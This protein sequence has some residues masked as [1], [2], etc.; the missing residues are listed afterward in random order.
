MCR[1]VVGVRKYAVGGDW[2]QGL[3][4]N[5]AGARLVAPVPLQ[6]GAAAAR[7]GPGCAGPRR[8]RRRRRPRAEHRVVGAVGAALQAQAGH[9]HPAQRTPGAQ[10]SR[11]A[12]GP[13]VLPPSAHGKTR[14]TLQIKFVGP[15]E[16][17]SEWLRALTKYSWQ[18]T[19]DT[20]FCTHGTPCNVAERARAPE[21]VGVVLEGDGDAG[22]RVGGAGVGAQHHAAGRQDDVLHEG[23]V[24]PAVALDAHRPR[25]VGEAD[26]RRA[27]GAQVAAAAACAQVPADTPIVCS[28]RI[29]N[30]I[31]PAPVINA[32]IQ[33][34]AL[35]AEAPVTI[36]PRG[37]FMPD[38]Y[39]RTMEVHIVLD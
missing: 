33:T 8:R 34:R 26:L 38:R 25:E 6:R 32:A 14:W 20:H 29:R 3:N 36:H 37:S 23:D 10:V 39:T 22:G 2:G 35:A 19:P 24:E 7:V 4:P 15:P 5:P 18:K 1:L 11:S 16:L 28:A 21:V 17:R 30:H 13:S 31:D 9:V 12:Q 27:A